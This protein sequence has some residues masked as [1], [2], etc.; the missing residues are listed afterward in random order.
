VGRAALVNVDLELGEA[1]AQHTRCA[2]VIEVDVRQEQHARL[3]GAEPVEQ[4]FDAGGR[5]GVDDQ[6]V[7]LVRADHAIAVH[8]HD[9]DGVGH[10]E[11]DDTG[12]TLN[13]ELRCERAPTA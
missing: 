2:R 4:G 13:I 10:E 3:D 6:T 7:D 5:P 8:V 9:V 12:G 1:P 11:T